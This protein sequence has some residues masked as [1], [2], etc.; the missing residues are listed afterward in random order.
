MPLSVE[1]LWI[2]GERERERE[3][4]VHWSFISSTPPQVWVIR[5][6]SNHGCYVVPAVPCRPLQCPQGRRGSFHLTTHTHT[7]TH[8]SRAHIFSLYTQLSLSI[9]MHTCVSR[10]PRSVLHAPPMCA[11]GH[12]VISSIK[13][14]THT[15]T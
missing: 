6:S 5:Q 7:H 15:H 4:G 8:S 10:L 3:T 2:E 12:G 9:H 11:R 14:H 13:T 1:L